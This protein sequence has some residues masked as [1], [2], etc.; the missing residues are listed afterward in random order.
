[1][2][3]N[4][5]NCQSQKCY[6]TINIHS[7]IVVFRKLSFHFKSIQNQYI[8]CRQQQYQYL[9]HTKCAIDRTSN[10]YYLSHLTTQQYKL[11]ISHSAKIKKPYVNNKH[12]SFRLS[13]QSSILY[14]IIQ[15]IYHRT[16]TR[17]YKLVTT[18]SNSPR[19]KKILVFLTV[20]DSNT[21]QLAQ[22]SP[23]ISRETKQQGQLPSY[24]P[25]KQNQ[26]GTSWIEELNR[27]LC[28]CCSQRKKK[29]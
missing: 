16:N 28:C 29:S 9:L 11:K 10:F 1:M 13:K 23:R 27:L 15:Y 20:L 2:Y 8:F 17:Y 7:Y 21:Q 24:P 3:K 26:I 12:R 6:S 18:L 19:I 14:N 4:T 22:A 5:C 25:P